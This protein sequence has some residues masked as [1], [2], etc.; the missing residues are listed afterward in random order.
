MSKQGKVYLVGAGP[1]DPELLTL[2]AHKSIVNADVILYDALVSKSIIN[3]NPLAE[4]IFVG[5]RKGFKAM[6]QTEINQLLVELAF[7]GKNIIRLK[8]GDPM[9]FGRAHEEILHCK[10]HNIECEIIPGIASYSGIASANKIPLTKRNEQE[11]FFITTGFTTNG[12]VSKDITLAA[13]SSATVVVLMG[14]SNLDKIV[15][16]FKKYQDESYPVAI[17]QNGTTSLEKSIVG[18]L[19][20]ILEL[21]Q[22]SEISNPANIIFGHAVTDEITEYKNL[23]LEE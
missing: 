10:I 8:G 17:I 4:K 2:K 7:L 23:I 5:K 15:E 9:V 20:N 19:S 3:L 16:I 11:S 21:V 12:E 22:E 13:K 1:G 18:N 6:E 14:M